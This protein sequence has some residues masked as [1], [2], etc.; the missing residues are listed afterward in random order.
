MRVEEALFR[1]AARR[2]H[3]PALVCG[4]QRLTYCELAERIRSRVGSHAPLERV[5]IQLPNGIEFVVQIFAAWAAGAVAVP[6][7]TRLA[8][9]EA[10]FILEELAAPVASEAQD[11][12]ILYTSGTT[13]RPKGAVNTHANVLAQNVEQHAAAWGIGEND[14]FLVTT[15]LAHRA[16]MAR[17]VNALGLG[18]TLVIMERFDARAALELVEREAI[19]VAGLP[20]TVIRMMLPELRRAPA[21]IRSLRTVVVST[22]AFP[23]P[24][25]R[26][27]AALAPGTQFHAVYGMSEAAVASATLAEQ[28]ERPGTVGRPLA[29]VAVRIAQDKE[30]LVR[31]ANA[32]MREYFNRPQA[33][34]EAFRDGWFHTGDLARQ[35]ADGY[36]YIIDRKK[37]MVVTGGYNV[38]CKEVEQALAQHPEI[39]EAAVLGV[40]D[41]VYGESV[42][43]FIELRA[44]AALTAEAIGAHCSGL[45]AG[46]KKPRFVHFVE[47]LPRN[48]LGKVLKEELRR[49]FYKPLPRK[50]NL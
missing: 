25:M 39:V 44:G 33:N 23:A 18:A 31:G 41:P 13:G 47:S 1:H 4:S 20:P 5:A 7:N 37:D 43:A 49:V 6:I 14:R 38:Y 24:L 22:E 9:P 26:E 21:R 45:L 11:C 42:A 2:P 32:V 19:T 50:G 17:L 40:P 46:Y 3:H 36:L 34:A 16:G 30:L 15:A 12:V 8:A 35:D 48:A 28:L 29:G 27:I 10:R